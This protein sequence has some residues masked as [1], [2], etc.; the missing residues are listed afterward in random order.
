MSYSLIYT[1]PITNKIVW[2]LENVPEQFELEL[3]TKVV[4][5]DL[6]EPCTFV[7][8]KWVDQPVE[9]SMQTHKWDGD[10]FIE[11]PL[12]SSLSALI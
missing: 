5:F 8:F 11:S 1:S 12:L 2:V 4:N 10:K 6:N 7:D 3:Y 9:V